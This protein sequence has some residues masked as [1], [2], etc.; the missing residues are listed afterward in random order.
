MKSEKLILTDCDGVLLDW[1]SKFIWWMDMFK[2][3][4]HTGK[5]DSYK[6]ELAFGIDSATVRACVNEFNESDHFGDL[7][8]HEDAGNVV[9]KMAYEEGYRFGVIT[10]CGIT[11]ETHARRKHNLMTIFGDVFEFVDCI[12]L[13]VSKEE[14]I[15]NRVFEYAPLVWVE[16]SISHA[17][18]GANLGLDSF[19]INQPYNRNHNDHRIIRVDSWSEIN[20]YVNTITKFR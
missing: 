12:P 16:D 4:H 13:N 8:P 7:L 15:R 18:T 1:Y 10:A 5:G 17:K 19:L 20:D 14:S 6:L 2:G 9:R 3:I 11:P